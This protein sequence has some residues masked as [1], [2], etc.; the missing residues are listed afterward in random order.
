[1]C[2]EE[3]PVISDNERTFSCEPS[4]TGEIAIISVFWLEGENGKQQMQTWMDEL[5]NSKGGMV[6]T[7]DKTNPFWQ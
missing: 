4:S 6:C 1:N 7:A 5:A 3:V 2:E